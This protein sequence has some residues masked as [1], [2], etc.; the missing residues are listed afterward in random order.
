NNTGLKGRRTIAE[1]LVVD[2][3]I[4]RLVLA[5]KDSSEI[6]KEAVKKGTKTLWD[7][8]LDLVRRGETTLEE[9]LRVSSDTENG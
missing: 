2:E 6:M 1:F 7:D 3:G 9:L 4:R 8:G 5:H